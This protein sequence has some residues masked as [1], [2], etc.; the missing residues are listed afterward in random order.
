MSWRDRLQSVGPIPI[1]RSDTS[2][3]SVTSVTTSTDSQHVSGVTE[4]LAPA[5]RISPRAPRLRGLKQPADDES[6][7]AL[8]K[9]AALLAT[10]YRRQQEIRRVAED[11]GDAELPHRVALS[12]AESVHGVVT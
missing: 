12:S 2:P 1:D 5:G 4:Q 11:H 3:T 9:I 10:A 8:R 6:I 7:K